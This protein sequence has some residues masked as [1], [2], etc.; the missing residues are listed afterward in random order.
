MFYYFTLTLTSFFL[1]LGEGERGRKRRAEE[2]R[3]MLYQ[4]AAPALVIS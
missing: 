3:R 1:T 4:E 2:R